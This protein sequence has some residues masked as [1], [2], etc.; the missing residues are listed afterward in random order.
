[1]PQSTAADS[2][3]ATDTSSFV[4]CMAECIERTHLGASLG[5]CEQDFELKEDETGRL[6][7]KCA[8]C[9]LETADAVWATMGTMSPPSVYWSKNVRSEG[10][11]DVAGELETAAS[12]CSATAAHSRSQPDFLFA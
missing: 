1:V 3:A 9:V 7:G 10:K 5:K 2:L 4:L 8:R 11:S 6:G 12:E